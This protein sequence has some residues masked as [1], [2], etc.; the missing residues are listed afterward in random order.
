MK[1]KNH[2]MIRKFHKISQIKIQ[3]KSFLQ[4]RLIKD[5]LKYINFM[6]MYKINNLKYKS[7]NKNHIKIIS[8]YMINSH[9]R[10]IKIL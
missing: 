3:K 10:K 5:L 9:L 2:I 8:I 4:M 1:K 6:K 7:K